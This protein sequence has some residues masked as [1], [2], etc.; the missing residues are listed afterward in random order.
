MTRGIVEILAGVALVAWSLASMAA[1]WR[2]PVD[3]P[4]PA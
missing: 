4:P 1:T 2:H 3:P